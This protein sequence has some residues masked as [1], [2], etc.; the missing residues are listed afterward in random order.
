MDP[1][2]GVRRVMMHAVSEV[3]GAIILISVAA[4]AMA[5]VCRGLIASPMPTN[6][7]SFSGLISNS[8]NTVYISHEGGDPLYVGQFKILVN[9]SDETAI[10]TKSLSSNVFSL[11]MKMNATLPHMPKRVVMV[12]NTSMGG[13]TVLLSIDPVSSIV[14]PPGV[15]A[16]SYGHKDR[17][18]RRR[19][20]QGGR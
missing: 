1:F 19:R 12:F 17:G 10:F 4:L 6:V 2:E 8:S 16:K 3:V 20:Y 13:G 18:E 11:G 15:G 9:G 14:I 7:P 5:I